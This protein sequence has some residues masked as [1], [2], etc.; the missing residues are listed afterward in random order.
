[1]GDDV[2]EAGETDSCLELGK[3]INNLC[4]LHTHQIHGSIL[5][6]RTK[7]YRRRPLLTDCKA[8]VISG[9]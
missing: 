8:A 4:T 6:G 1:M 5:I 3:R 7:V 9:C 2:P